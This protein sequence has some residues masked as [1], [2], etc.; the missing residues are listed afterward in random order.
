VNIPRGTTPIRYDGRDRITIVGQPIS[1]VRA[2]WLTGPG[3]LLAG[4]WEMPRVS[5][6][7]RQYTIPIGEDLGRGQGTAPFSDFDYV[8][9]SIMAAYDATVVQ[10]DTNADGVFDRTQTINAGETAFVRGSVD[11]ATISIH[12]GAK[13][14]SSLPVQVQLRAGNCRAPYSGRSYTLVPVEKW[15]NDYWSPV[16]SFVIGVNGCVVGYNPPQP[17]ASAD[18]DI[19]IVNPNTAPLVVNYE[20]AGGAGPLT[21]PPNSTAS[22]LKLLGAQAGLQRS[23]TQGVHLFSTQRFWAVTAVDT[24]SLGNNGADFDWSYSLIPANQLSARV[25][26]SWAPGNANTPPTAGN[27]VNG[28]TVYVQ[29]TTDGTTVRADLN[30]DGAFDNFDINGDSDAA[31]LNAYG[32]N[33]TTSSVG[34]TLNRGQTV[35]ISDPNDNDMTGA[36]I[37]SQD[38]SHP[39]AVVFG[40]DACRA[41][42]AL[43][44]LDLGYTVLPLPIPEISKNSR[45]LIDADRSSDIS[46]GD[47]LEYRVQVFNNG[48]GPIQQPILLDTLPFTYTDF[49]V[50]SASSS[51][52]PNPPG[53]T[54]DNGSGTFTYVPTGASGSTDPQVHAVRANYS[55]L[56]QGGTLVITLHIKLDNQIPPNVLAIT[57]QASMTSSNTPPVRTEVTSPIN[58][59]DL[60]IHKT[61]GRTVVN[62]LDQVTYT[63]TYTNAGPGIARN[64][65]MTDTL[66][67][68]AFDVS[69]PTVPGVVTPTID[70]PNRRVIFQLG[71][72]RPL[73]VGQTTI[74]L[75]LSDRTVTPVVNTVDIGTSSH[76]T[77]YNNNHSVDID[78][79]P[80][81]DILVTKTDGR[82]Q[83]NPGQPIVYTLTYTNAG[84]GIAF[85]AV[86]TDTLPPTA[87]NPSTPTVPGVITPTID[88]ANGR[89]IFQLGHLPPGYVGNTTVSL[90]LAPNTP[91]G[92][93]VVNTVA[94]STTSHDPNE[95][96]NHHTDI[97]VV[98]GTNAVV[99]AELRAERRDGGVQ[100]LWRTVAEQ[101]NYGFR[102]YRSSTP[103][104]A[105]AQ[106]LTPDIIPGQGRGQAGGASYSFFDTSAPDGPAYYWLEDIDMNGVSEFHGPAQPTTQGALIRIF[107]PRVGS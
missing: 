3:P 77:N 29:A 60:L 61:D 80:P 26:L 67:I 41:R 38:N 16:S 57:N 54:Y 25:A 5:D 8:S 71:T 104:R 87:L 86:M 21:V 39:L 52:A 13:I 92:S 1:A 19:Y 24:T 102:V 6:W 4:A 100:V 85:N 91:R 96:N 97:D 99:L 98:P 50:G 51:P 46:P 44:F 28:S 94:I 59:V 72:L 37:N 40:E 78:Q 32:Y 68:T 106:L 95:S 20:N 55:I 2:A 48:Y 73:Q 9:A 31:D 30:G 103:S 43:P 7:G 64:V 62:P 79:T 42:R 66:P 53:I 74:T 12:S 83:V 65:I 35:R 14:S 69:S 15:S 84:P 11:P 93:N 47:T 49:V 33:E 27:E 81:A 70:L 76:E 17:N 82:R 10:I 18:V 75:R 34:V 107:L 90:T 88:L 63:L 36:I 23:N 101:D 105:G 22:Y 56:P 58:Q 45:L 89:I